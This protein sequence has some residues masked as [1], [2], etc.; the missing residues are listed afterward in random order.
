L[1]A[2]AEAGFKIVIFSGGEPLLREDIFLLIDYARTIGL[3]PVLGTNG[4]L[5]TTIVAEKLLAA[6][7][8][9]VGISID[10]LTPAKHDYLRQVSGAW[11]QAMHGIA[12]CREVGLPFQLHTTVTTWN[13]AEITDI[14]DLAVQLGA[15]A[16]HIFFLVPTG[17]GKD[18]APFAL[19]T[20][21]YEVLLNRILAKQSRVPIELK[22]T[23]APQFMRLVHQRQMT[24]RYRRG[25][26]AGKAY[27]VVL[28]NGDVQPCA[29]LPVVAGNVLD[30]DF[31]TLW[32]GG[33]IFK[34]LREARLR[35]A[36][37]R[38][39][40]TKVCGGCRAR[41]YYAVGDYMAAD[42]LCQ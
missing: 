24:I 14:T 36:C 33:P 34:Q 7:L 12:A 29:Y 22:P 5:I 18:L 6:G 11:D 38:C 4:T 1:T 30:Q 17:R 37:G 8:A 23:C 32:R 2:L 27:C 3:R 39:L 31:I 19:K 26:L 25:C 40:Y 16:H 15:I 9:V 20:D 10:S 42:P 13:E 21:Q 28:P 35:G 41:A